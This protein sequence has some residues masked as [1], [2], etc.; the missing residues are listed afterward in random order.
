LHVY[1]CT[2]ICNFSLGPGKPDP[3]R[4]FIHYLI[5]ERALTQT[6]AEQGGGEGRK[7]NQAGVK[8]PG[9]EKTFL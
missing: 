5:K 4:A 9:Q 8:E 3:E 1:V 6:R 7:N 2:Y